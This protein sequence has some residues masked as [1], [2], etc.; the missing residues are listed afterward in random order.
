MLRAMPQR[1]VVI[2][3]GGKG[4]RFWPQSRLRRPKQLLP[5]VGDTSMLTQTV[6]PGW[7][8]D[9][10]LARRIW[11][12]HHASGSSAHR[13]VSATQPVPFHGHA[14]QTLTGASGA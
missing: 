12:S 2:M 9:T 6:S 10:I 5:I 1:F 11:T 3:A 14:S 13:L 7:L 8:G 4:E